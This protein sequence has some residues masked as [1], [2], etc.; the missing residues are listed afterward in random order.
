[1]LPG[2]FYVYGKWRARIPLLG[3]AIYAPVWFLLIDPDLS[4]HQNG[5]KMPVLRLE[6]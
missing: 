4:K 5:Q 6:F 3:T 1:M 2:A